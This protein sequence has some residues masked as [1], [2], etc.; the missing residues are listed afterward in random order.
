MDSERFDAIARLFGSGVSRRRALRAVAAGAT[1]ATVGSVASAALGGEPVEAGKKSKKRCLKAGK[2]C[3]SNKQCC[4]KSDLKCGVPFG[5]GNS[6]TY[7]CGGKG[8]TCGG[9]NELG[10][11]VGKKCCQGFSCSTILDPDDPNFVP[12]K[13]GKCVRG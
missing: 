7:C 13:K 8:A 3:S 11:A 12:F 9:A 10:D 2:K 5:S 6:D 4:S 1:V